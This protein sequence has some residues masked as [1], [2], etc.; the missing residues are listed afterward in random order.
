MRRPQTFFLPLFM[1]TVIGM[2]VAVIV[3]VYA[4]RT[5]AVARGIDRAETLFRENSC[6]GGFAQ[7]VRIS[8]WANPHPA[9]VSRLRCTAIIG[10]VH[11]GDD[12]GALVLADRVLEAHVSVPRPETIWV[13]LYQQASRFLDPIW[14]KKQ[15][16]L[17]PDQEAGYQTMLAE[18]QRLNDPERLA[19]FNARLASLPAPIRASRVEGVPAPP[20]SPRTTSI[21]KPTRHPPSMAEPEPRTESDWGAG[22]FAV[23]C[24]AS[25]WVYN[26]D[27]K[28]TGE[29]TP[30]TLLAVS[31]IR[32]GEGEEI[33][34]CQPADAPLNAPPLLVRT[35]DLALYDGDLAR[36]SPSIHD[37]LVRR[38]RIESELRQQ[39]RSIAARNPHAAAY[40]EATAN[41]K[42]FIANVKKTTALRDSTTG[43]ERMRYAT[44]LHAMKNEAPALRE[45][46]EKSKREYGEWK[47]SHGS[48]AASA[49]QVVALQTRLDK[50]AAELAQYDL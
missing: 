25:I 10:H 15:G 36:L 12:D 28:H 29:V 42:A 47:A 39:R 33:A 31:D 46:Y 19:S 5:A 13:A 34:V 17:A 1:V 32:K 3:A 26:T 16:G 35:R 23:A 6:D 41:Y 8:Y 24:G 18:L 4:A 40:K 2:T 48:D 49:P 7:L 44:D 21:A 22:R 11:L 14:L 27:G 50:V 20:P 38:G 37:L 45:A 9:L 30:G 43:A